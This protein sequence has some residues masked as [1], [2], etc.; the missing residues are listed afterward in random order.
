MRAWLNRHPLLSTV[1]TIA[2]LL[3]FLPLAP[4]I[5]Q[6]FTQVIL[7]DGTASAPAVTFNSDLDTGFYR[8]GTGRTGYAADGVP[9]GEMKASS[10]V[11]PGQIRMTQTTAPVLSSCSGC[12]LENG[13]TDSAWRVN[14]A[15][16]LASTFTITF[17]TAFSSEPACTAQDETT[18]N[19]NPV[20]IQALATSIVVTLNAAAASNDRVSG[21]CVGKTG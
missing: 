20:R 21:I 13:A 2:A 3:I 9:S 18:T 16:S 4:V 1:A 10:W 17:A 14:L 6:N 15:E 8:I 5:A 12:A 19:K 7:L 11:A